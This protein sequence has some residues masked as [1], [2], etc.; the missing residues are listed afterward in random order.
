M[1]PDGV[2]GHTAGKVYPF[3]QGMS[4]VIGEVRDEATADQIVERIKAVRLLAK[5]PV[6]QRAL[7]L[8]ELMVERRAAELQNQPGPHADKALAALERAFKREWSAGEPRLMADFLGGARRDPA[9]GAGEGATAPTGGAALRRRGRHVRPAAHRPPV[10]RDAQRVL[11]PPGGD[12]PA[13]GRAEGVR[14]REQGRAPDLREQ[15]PGDAD[16]PHGGRGALRPRREAAPRPAQAPGS[17]GTEGVA[18]RA[19]ERAV[20]PGAAEQGRSLARQ[21]GGAVQ[22]AGGQAVRGPGRARPEPPLP[23]LRAAH[24]HVPRGPPAQTRR[25]RRRPEGVRVQAAPANPEGPDRQLRRGRARLRRHAT[26]R[27]RCPRRD[28]LLAGPH[29][30]RAGLAAVHQPRRVEPVRL[31]A[32]RVARRGEGVGRPGAALPEGRAGGVAPRPP[33]ARGPRPHDLRPRAHLLLGREG[34]RVREGGRGGARRAEG[35]ERG[36]RVHRRVPVLRACRARSGRSRFCSRRTSRRCCPKPGG[37]G[38][39]SSSTSRSGTRSRS[40]CSWL[41]WNCGRTRSTTAPS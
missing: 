9:G 37:G 19:P 33:L 10:R 32:R 13:S 20:P 38:S 25:C 7:D 6:D 5:T 26:R 29:R 11:P 12:R 18:G 21:R 14:G 22:G 36:G 23:A 27:S 31:P 28:R 15:R 17:P 8:L 30:E 16:L 2:I 4:G 39:P 3:L 40:R 35:V 1:L 34:G 41:S 24:A